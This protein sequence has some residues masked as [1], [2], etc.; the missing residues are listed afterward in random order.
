MCGLH[1]LVREACD[2]AT[3][4]DNVAKNLQDPT[5]REPIVPLSVS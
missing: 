4:S 3:L 5:R 2:L 1:C